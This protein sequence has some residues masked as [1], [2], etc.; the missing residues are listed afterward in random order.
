MKHPY[1]RVQ[2]SQTIDLN[3]AGHDNSVFKKNQRSGTNIYEVMADLRI[4]YHLTV[5]YNLSITSIFITIP[6]YSHQ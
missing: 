2:M 1:K 3:R 6:R 4:T 5:S